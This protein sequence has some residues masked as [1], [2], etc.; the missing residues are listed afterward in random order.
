MNVNR[1]HLFETGFCYVSNSYANHQKY[2][3]YANGGIDLVS[4]TANGVYKEAKVLACADGT[5]MYSGNG[6]GYGNAVWIDHG[7]KY[8]SGY[9]HMKSLLV[10]AGQFVKKGTPIGIIGTTGNSTGIHL[11]FE[12]RL[13]KAEY[14]IPPVVS[15]WAPESFMTK[16]KFTWVDPTSYIN[17]DLPLKKADETPILNEE[18][19]SKSTTPNR[20]KVRVNGSQ[21]GAYTKYVGACNEATRRGGVVIDGNTNKQIFPPV[22]KEDYTKSTIPNRFRVRLAVNGLQIGA[23]TSYN[24]AVSIARAK[25]AHIYDASHGMECIY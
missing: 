9:G 24:S 16:S 21:V 8:V 18:D 4:C 19:Y 1:T 13:Y 10:K 22:A 11:H 25:N 7:Q 14:K 23:Y 2:T 6:D 17:R 3:S 12:I 20:F 5:V 15:F